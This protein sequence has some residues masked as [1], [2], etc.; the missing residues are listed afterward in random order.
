MKCIY[1]CQWDIS[2]S[3]N[4]LPLLILVP[5][6]FIVIAFL[7]VKF[8][9][10]FLHLNVLYSPIRNKFSLLGNAI[11]P[12]IYIY[13]QMY[14]SLWL[15]RH[16]AYL[17]ECKLFEDQVKVDLSYNLKHQFTIFIEWALDICMWIDGWMDKWLKGWIHTWQ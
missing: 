8:K 5:H 10:Y 9:H 17:L 3:C 2:H 4:G 15:H 7:N 12:N 13:K 1:T 6:V 16:L 14:V 11:A